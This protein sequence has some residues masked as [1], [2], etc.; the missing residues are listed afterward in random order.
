M[1]C[2]YLRGSSSGAV[3]KPAT[4]FYVRIRKLLKMSIFSY[5]FNKHPI[6]QI[7]GVGGRRKFY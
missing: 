2:F 5:E 1:L 4:G 6:P 3:E 7:M